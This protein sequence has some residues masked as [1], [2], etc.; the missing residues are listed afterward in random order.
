MESR[1]FISYSHDD[2]AEVRRFVDVL[3]FFGVR[4]WWDPEL[5]P[6]EGFD[7]AIK[8]EIAQCD[9]AVLLVSPSYL[10]SDYI[11]DTEI[12]L[13]ARR[14]V[15]LI[16]VSVKEAFRGR[17][18]L[19]K[20]GKESA[21]DARSKEQVRLATLSWPIS[22]EEGPLPEPDRDD[23][24]QN[25]VAERIIPEIKRALEL[26]GREHW[27]RDRFSAME[28]RSVES[29]HVGTAGVLYG[30]VDESAD[31]HAYRFSA[32]D[33]NLGTPITFQSDLIGCKL[34]AEGDLLALQID[35]DR[36]PGSSVILRDIGGVP[37]TLRVETSVDSGILACWK[38]PTENFAHVTFR[39]GSRI[40]IGIPGGRHC[41]FAPGD[42]SVEEK[43]LLVRHRHELSESIAWASSGGELLASGSCRLPEA[44]VQ[45]DGSL[46]GWLDLDLASFKEVDRRRVVLLGIRKTGQADDSPVELR[47]AE[48]TVV[49]GGVIDWQRS[50]CERLPNDVEASR[51][52]LGRSFHRGTPET[53]GQRPSPAGRP[54]IIRS[55]DMAWESKDIF[56]DGE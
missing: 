22:P 54:A 50:V 45:G 5:V 18:G 41:E 23:D 52:I 25:L 1:V 15:P 40:A 51:V 44:L 33:R 24:Y 34:S 43:A 13:L 31:D 35:N 29:L 17:F 7:E 32:E 36:K 10:T 6:G 8:Q 39:D 37:R 47:A 2:M 42:A 56:G 30:W 55:A 11:W 14:G 4:F 38:S 16:P 48:G 46:D 20:A 12:T 3:E 19:W 26:R 28:A 21:S 49:S 9:A 27:F 53:G